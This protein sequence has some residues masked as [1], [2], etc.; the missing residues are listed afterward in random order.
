MISSR[1]AISRVF[2]SCSRGSILGGRQFSYLSDGDKN[3]EK[4]PR[5]QTHRKVNDDTDVGA[6]A[7]RKS[8][9][10]S[11][12]PYAGGRWFVSPSEDPQ[13]FVANLLIIAIFAYGV[14]QLPAVGESLPV[15]RRRIIK[16]RIRQEY[17]LPIGWDD[18]IDGE[19][20]V[21]TAEV[22][23]VSKTAP[24]DNKPSTV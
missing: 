21:L 22:L 20:S 3:W 24:A 15:R 11:M 9:R 12:G 18:E 13:S 19:D 5:F 23:E 6:Q 17:G 8:K 10:F 2:G 14:M 4:D 16:D 1:T 7:P